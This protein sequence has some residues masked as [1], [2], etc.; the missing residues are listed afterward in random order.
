MSQG[1]PDPQKPQDRTRAI[2][3]STLEPEARLVAVAIADHMDA[4]GEAWP[5]GATLAA[6]TGYC[7]RTVLDVIGHGLE[8]GWLACRW[9]P[10]RRRV[11]R[12]VWER[13]NDAGRPNRNAGGRK[14]RKASDPERGAESIQNGAPEGDDSFRRPVPVRSGAPLMFD[15]A[16]GAGSIRNG[17]PPKQTNEATIEAT[18]EA[19]TFSAPAPAVAEPAP[20]AK[21]SPKVKPEPHPYH[22]RVIDAWDRTW[23][24]RNPGTPY[25]WS[26]RDV[27]TLTRAVRDPLVHRD[28]RGVEDLQRVGA[29]FRRYLG[30]QVD[31]RYV[32]GL[33]IAGFA[34]DPALWFVATSSADPATGAPRRRSSARVPS[35]AELLNVN[36]EHP[37]DGD[38]VVIDIT[39]RTTCH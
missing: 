26:P 31:G 33:S 18:S 5:N 25:P 11:L 30:Q 36:H 8:T 27:A 32:R 6:E 14:V 29:A 15:P 17:A 39:P 19:T 22:Q 9:L 13:L 28:E 2:L 16:P 3:R 38:R 1:T 23:A 4:D 21:R 10:G 12:V 20:K 24:E 34:R 35:L 7:E 37:T